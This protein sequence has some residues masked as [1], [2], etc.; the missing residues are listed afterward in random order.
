MNGLK[1]ANK[2]ICVR[3][4]HTMGNLIGTCHLI[5]LFGIHQFDNWLQLKIIRTIY[6][7]PLCKDEED[8]IFFAVHS[9][10]QDLSLS[11]IEK[12]SFFYYV[13]QILPIIG[14][15]HTHIVRNSI[16]LKKNRAS[17]NED[18]FHSFL[19]C[20][21]QMLPVLQHLKRAKNSLIFQKCAKCTLTLMTNYEIIFWL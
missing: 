17:D 9:S 13:E 16:W 10:A 20:S 18:K 4:D 2:V 5:S 19:M 3:T 8:L 6:F 12:V 11:L 14:H 7:I 21:N 1:E 15:L